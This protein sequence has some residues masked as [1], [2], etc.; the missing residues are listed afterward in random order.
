MFQKTRQVADGFSEIK[1][2]VFQLETKIKVFQLETRYTIRC[3]GISNKYPKTGSLLT[4][5]V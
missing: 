5:T 1:I 2:T 3:L 4:F